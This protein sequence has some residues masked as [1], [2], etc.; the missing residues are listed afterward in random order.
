[1]SGRSRMSDTD[2]D[3]LMNERMAKMGLSTT[4]GAPPPSYGGKPRNSGKSLA[5]EAAEMGYS[6][7]PKKRVDPF[8]AAKSSENQAY[9][10]DSKKPVKKVWEEEDDDETST[11]SKLEVVDG[12]YP[13]RP[14]K[15][16]CAMWK[17]KGKCLQ[18]LRS[19][20]P[21]LLFSL[22]SYSPPFSTPLYLGALLYTSL[23]R[24][25][26]LHLSI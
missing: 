16:V 23:S 5:E 25:P 8:E 17:N 20:N 24:S 11:G 18:R 22:A 2:R 26:S 9:A 13:I 15:M 6:R 14:G 1:M 12:C 21:L 19:V 7:P 4:A 3:R 10:R